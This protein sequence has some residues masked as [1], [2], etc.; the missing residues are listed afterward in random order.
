M[1]VVISQPMLFPWVGMLEQI[2]LADVFIHYDDVQF[3]KG[4]FTNRVQLKTA[5]GMRWLT[6][7]LGNLS[8][9]MSIA[10]ILV[11]DRKDW[12]SSHRSLLAQTFEKTPYAADALALANA[13]YDTQ[14]D[15]LVDLLH[16]GFDALA[17]YFDIRPKRVL[18]SSEMG[19]G[20]KSSARV[21]ACVKEVGG[22][23]YVTGHGA[24]N[25]LDHELF[26]REGVSVEYMN[27]QKRP[28][29]QKHGSFTPFVSA[30]DLVANLGRAGRDHICS[31]TV[32]WKEFIAS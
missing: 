4:S 19:V 18:R 23:V 12:R 13:V 1:R 14:S 22:D 11:D 27:Y 15:R 21:L 6:I 5:Q 32:S 17:S 28:Y 9:G 24:S 7:P 20:G 26:G 31:G 25:Y 29:A 10:D 8:L 30:L 16:V 2:R 3:S